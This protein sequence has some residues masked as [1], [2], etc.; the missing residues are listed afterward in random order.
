MDYLQNH[1]WCS[2][3]NWGCHYD[4][5]HLV[6]IPSYGNGKEDWIELID[7]NINKVTDPNALERFES[8]LSA[9]Y[10]TENERE[11]F[12]SKRAND[13][14]PHVVQWLEKNVKDRKDPDCVKGWCVGSAEYVAFDSSA[15]FTVF[16]HRK[17]DAM[18]FIKTFSKY[19]KPINYCQY[20]SDVRKKLNIDT[21]KYENL[22]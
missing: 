11:M 2:D 5:R 1:I 19:K 20:F 6:S 18:D 17:S 3:S 22:S 15:S 12:T 4:C 10:L 8:M 14:K 16:F 7:E 21:M 13:L 9:G